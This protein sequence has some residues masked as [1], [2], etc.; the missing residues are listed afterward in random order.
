[1]IYGDNPDENM[2]ERSVR[3]LI[4]LLI[5]VFDPLAVLMLIAANLTQIKAKQWR[6]EKEE[7]N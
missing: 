6:E 4:I 7:G 3:W 2:L 1:M 5:A